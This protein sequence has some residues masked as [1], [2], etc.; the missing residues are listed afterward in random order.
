MCCQC[1]CLS[2]SFSLN[3]ENFVTKYYSFEGRTSSSF[4]TYAMLFITAIIDL[5]ILVPAPLYFITELISQVLLNCWIFLCKTHYKQYRWKNNMST[6]YTIQKRAS[7]QLIIQSTGRKIPGLSPF[8]QNAPDRLW[9]QPSLLFRVRGIPPPAIKQ[10]GRETEHSLQSG[11][12]VDNKGNYLHGLHRNVF[13]L[14]Q[15]SKLSVLLC[16]TGV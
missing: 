8:L 9:C 1:C 14:K 2:N 11:T 12:E 4:L 10:L 15:T 6:V 13:I 16:N 3:T 7:T 5:D